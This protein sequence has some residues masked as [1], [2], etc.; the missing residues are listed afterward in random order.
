MK[1]QKYL[2]L[3]FLICSICKFI[4]SSETTTKEPSEHEMINGDE[5]VTDDLATNLT[6][7]FE[8][9]PIPTLDTS[10]FESFK[11]VELVK[12]LTDRPTRSSSRFT[13]IG[14]DSTRS[15]ALI[16]S[17]IVLTN[18]TSP[19]KR[20]LINSMNTFTFKLFKHLLNKYSNILISPISLYSSLIALHAASSGSTEAQ[21]TKLL[22]LNGVSEK[23]I[24][25]GYRLIIDSM[26]TS[27]GE[28]N[29]FKLLNAML[30]DKQ[31]T[32]SSSYQ[33]KMSKLY[34][35]VI[36]SVAFATEGEQIYQYVNNMVNWRT[37]GNIA[38]VLDDRPDPLSKLLLVNA[39]HFKGQWAKSF[40]PKETIL[41]NFRNKD[42]EPTKIRMMK[43]ISDFDVYCDNVRQ[44]GQMAPICSVKIPY[45]G[46][47]LSMQIIQS[48]TSRSSLKESVESRL[49][50]QLL[51]ELDLKY[52]SKQLELGL[53]SFRLEDAHEL[54][55]PMEV[56]GANSMFTKDKANLD[57]FMARSGKNSTAIRGP[58][59]DLFVNQFKHKAS[60][61]VNEQ[62]TTAS[63]VTSVLIGNRNSPNKFFIDRPF[64]F[65]IRDNRSGTILFI[66]RI[67][68]LES[69]E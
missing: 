31:I 14:L 16:D 9:P 24:A 26:Q 28:Q 60:I 65:L 10:I 57:K 7:D 21:L 29:Q 4:K 58:K 17:N 59:D 64:I 48:A 54:R 23:Q 45:A 34:N 15:A 63:A 2:I 18:G 27:L 11:S 25:I 47:Q 41:M 51:K 42:T 38:S 37:D 49:N 13:T 33:E 6:P 66:G 50:S 44:R 3:V 61:S 62:G 36:E 19:S 53:P 30:V 46:N 69:S 56:L 20:L 12:N 43:I 39:V 32:V 40:N 67:E 5:K 8:L 55:E 22:A 35:M 1:Q 52:E 68:N